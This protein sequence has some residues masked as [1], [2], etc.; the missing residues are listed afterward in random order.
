MLLALSAKS[1][2]LVSFSKYESSTWIKP[3]VYELD[4]PS[5][6]PAGISAIELIS[7]PLSL[8]FLRTSLAIGCLISLGLDTN[9]VFEYLI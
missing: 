8:N 1:F 3:T 7:I 6:V 9:Y 2:L 4:E 5:P